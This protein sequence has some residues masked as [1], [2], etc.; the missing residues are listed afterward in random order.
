MRF[1]ELK[2]NAFRLI[3]LKGN[4]FRMNLLKGN[5]FRMNLLLE[6]AFRMNLGKGISFIQEN[7]SCRDLY[8]QSSLGL[9]EIYYVKCLS[10]H[11]VNVYLK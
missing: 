1:H 11:P 10:F 3:L 6:N 7:N 9:I 4:M 5:A 8:N 2:E